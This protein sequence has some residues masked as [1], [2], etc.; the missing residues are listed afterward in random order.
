M[1]SSDS[2]KFVWLF[3]VRPRGH[4][5]HSNSFGRALGDVVL[6]RG[7]SEGRL[8]HSGSLGSSGIVGF[9]RVR[10]RVHS[11]SVIYFGCDQG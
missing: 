4:W 11:G 3:R 8:F 9:I 5:V 1:G 2:L 7:R 10:P 6:I